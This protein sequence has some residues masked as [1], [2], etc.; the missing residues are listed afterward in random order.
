MHKC[1]IHGGDSF[2][3]LHSGVTCQENVSIQQNPHQHLHCG[4]LA[5]QELAVYLVADGD[6]KPLQLW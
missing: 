1:G 2:P 4:I 6:T 3:E 5:M